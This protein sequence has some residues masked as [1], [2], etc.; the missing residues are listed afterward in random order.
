MLSCILSCQ[1]V[2]DS[3]YVILC[4]TYPSNYLYSYMPA[5]YIGLLVLPRSLT[6]QFYIIIKYVIDSKHFL[7]RQK[8]IRITKNSES[9]IFDFFEF[10]PRPFFHLICVL[11]KIRNCSYIASNSN[12]NCNNL[13]SFQIVF[14]VVKFI[15]LMMSFLKYLHFYAWY[16]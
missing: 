4:H 2:T 7:Q 14:I 1:C 3:K 11:K 6:S 12:W 9:S 5:S 8:W 10:C 15:W 16:R 13:K